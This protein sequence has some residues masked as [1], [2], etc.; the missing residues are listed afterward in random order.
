MFA[1]TFFDMVNFIWE[2]IHIE[3]CTY[4]AIWL[5]QFHINQ[6]FE[7]V[8]AMPCV[9]NKLTTRPITIRGTGVRKSLRIGN[10]SFH[11]KQ[12]IVTSDVLRDIYCDIVM[13]HL[14]CVHNLQNLHWIACWF[15]LN[16]LPQS[17][18]GCFSGPGFSVMSSHSRMQRK[19]CSWPLR[20][21]FNIY[22]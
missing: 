18:Q 9:L 3:I 21:H 19:S 16:G 6:L 20:L 10:H 2:I 5:F 13:V 1:Q 12:K 11:V 4:E 22:F 8:L 17:V 7:G 15:D 14:L